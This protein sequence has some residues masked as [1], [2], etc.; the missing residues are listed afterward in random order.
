MSDF[1][2]G[3]AM[4]LDKI[5]ESKGADLKKDMQQLP[6]GDALAKVGLLSQHLGISLQQALDPSLGE[7]DYLKIAEGGPDNA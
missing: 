2:D 6:P 7:E 5:A 1:I 4:I 3:R